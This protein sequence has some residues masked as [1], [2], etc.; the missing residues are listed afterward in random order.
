MWDEYAETVDAVIHLGQAVGFEFYTVEERAFN[1]KFTSTWGGAT[2]EM[3]G[4]YLTPDG[5]GKTVRDIGVHEGRGM[6][7]DVPMGL[8]TRVDVP[9]IIDDV[10]GTINSEDV[11]EGE[12]KM[13]LKVVPHFEAGPYGCGYTFYESLATCWKR[14][15]DNKVLFCHVPGWADE[16]RLKRGADVVCAIIGAV[17][18][19]IHEER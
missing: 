11:R 18:K 12:K 16:E 1:E 2:E 17:C 10:M 15:L 14:K 4:Y 7:D 8:A 9:T 3:E 13:V 19:Q 5:V 6:W